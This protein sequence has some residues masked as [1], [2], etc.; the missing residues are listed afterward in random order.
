VVKVGFK[1]PF[2]PLG[3][4]P[5]PAIIGFTLGSEVGQASLMDVAGE[6]RLIDVAG[7]LARLAENFQDLFF[8][9]G[10]P[11]LAKILALFFNRGACPPPATM[12]LRRG[13]RRLLACGQLNDRLDRAAAG[14]L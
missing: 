8:A 4:V 10:A 6:Y 7:S 2:D 11:S 5:I 1:T 14:V 3:F 13:G 12:A 9:V